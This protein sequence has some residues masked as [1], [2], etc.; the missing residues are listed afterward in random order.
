[1]NKMNDELIKTFTLKTDELGTAISS[2][3]KIAE[4]I[5]SSLF[6]NDNLKAA[7]N[8]SLLFEENDILI[9]KIDE[10]SFS[11]FI[12]TNNSTD[13]Y[14]VRSP[15]GVGAIIE[16]FYNKKEVHSRMV[17]DELLQSNEFHNDFH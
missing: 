8:A 6:N 12:I 10:D 2:F 9:K 15:N 11:V 4:N 17:K 14:S 7:N 13:M 1:M 16:A 3:Q 5:L